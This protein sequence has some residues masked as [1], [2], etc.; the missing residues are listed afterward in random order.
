[1]IMRPFGVQFTNCVIPPRIWDVLSVVGLLAGPYPLLPVPLSPCP[2]QTNLHVRRWAPPDERTVHAPAAEEAQQVAPR[3]WTRAFAQVSESSTLSSWGGL[4][5]PCAATVIT[6]SRNNVVP[7]PPSLPYVSKTSDRT[8]APYRF[9]FCVSPATAAT[10][11]FDALS[12]KSSACGHRTLTSIQ[13]CCRTPG[14][15]ETTSIMA[16]A[17]H[18][19]RF[20][21]CLHPIGRAPGH[22]APC[23]RSLQLAQWACAAYTGLPGAVWLA[24]PNLQQKE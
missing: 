2:C 17:Q 8:A 15:Q 24:P 5:C 14:N 12:L 1:M 18:G 22:G 3:P 10:P 23:P 9:V 21:F 19:R 16:A 4:H 20:A 11:G 13:S 6:K 7:S